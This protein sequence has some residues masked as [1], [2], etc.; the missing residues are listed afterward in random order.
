MASNFK[1][2]PPVAATKNQSRKGE[3]L[4]WFEKLIRNQ[5]LPPLSIDSAHHD[6]V[7]GDGRKHVLAGF[8]VRGFTYD[9]EHVLSQLITE[10]E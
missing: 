6:H 1:L 4:K 10:V 8:E 3:E 7:L 2:E 5:D 9:E